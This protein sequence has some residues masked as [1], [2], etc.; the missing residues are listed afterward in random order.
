MLRPSTCACARHLRPDG[1]MPRKVL[2]SRAPQGR[3]VR[4]GGRVVACGLCGECR[5]LGPGAN[6]T[7]CCRQRPPFQTGVRLQCSAVALLAS[8]GRREGTAW[9]KERRRSLPGWAGGCGSP[10]QPPHCRR[11]GRRRSFSQTTAQHQKRGVQ[12]LQRAATTTTTKGRDRARATAA[13]FCAGILPWVC[14]LHLRSAAVRRSQAAPARPHLPA[15]CDSCACTPCSA[16]VP[17]GPAAPPPAACCVRCA[18][19]CCASSSSGLGGTKLLGSLGTCEGPG[20]QGC[21]L[22]NGACKTNRALSFR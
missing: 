15:S 14:R 4:V 3:G 9:R 5:P 1:V 2:C 7:S 10:D 11:A 8:Y 13:T 20:A 22:L 19:S 6:A 17:E 16:A 21:R 12:W 18:S